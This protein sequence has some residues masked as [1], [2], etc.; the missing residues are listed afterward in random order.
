M[1]KNKYLWVFLSI[2][3]VVVTLTGYLVF[4]FTDNKIFDGIQTGGIDVSHLSKKEAMRK[5]AAYEE[6]YINLPILLN[7]Q[8]KTYL[9]FPKDDG[10]QI[11]I[12]ETV[13][14]AWKMGRNGSIWEQWM[15]RRKN[16]RRGVK[17]NFLL[18][19]DRTKLDR[20]LANLKNELDCNPVSAQIIENN[21]N[22]PVII[23]AITGRQL[24]TSK[25]KSLLLN[26]IFQKTQRRI[27]L[28]VTTEKPRLTQED[29]NRYQFKVIGSYVTRFN[30]KLTER[31]HNIR[32]AAQ[33]IN[34]TI[35]FPDDLL[36]FNAL[37]G[38]R[39]SQRGYLEAQ[40]MMNG[41]LTPGIGGGVCQVSTTLYNAALLARLRVEE[42]RN[43]GCLITYVP[44]GHDAAVQYGETDLKIRNIQPSP[45]VIT[46][47]VIKDQVRVD[48]WGEDLYPGEKVKFDLIVNRIIPYRTVEKVDFG[49]EPGERIIENAGVDGYEV[50][51]YRLITKNQRDLK[52]ALVNRSYYLSLAAK[53]R[54]GPPVKGVAGTQE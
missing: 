38:E 1:F 31:T 34:G 4:Y 49:L 15:E 47:R 41:V 28:P 2:F 46:C 25:L 53:V 5:L 48:I 54:T 11:D 50:S 37:V 27:D 19:A 6:E 22:K 30:P 35:V 36:S 40:V 14:Q 29:I 8:A 13:H 42:R 51:L 3:T 26:A 52:R 16:K 9:F 17:I 45:I 10:L 32:L 23:D 20:Y 7:Y 18:Q 33:S 24:D 21:Q 43:H 44:P 12:P 39:L